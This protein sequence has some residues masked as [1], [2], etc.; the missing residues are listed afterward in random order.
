MEDSIGLSL[1][2]PNG[3]LFRWI[4]LDIEKKLQDGLVGN[5][6]IQPQ[7]WFVL[8]ALGSAFPLLIGPHLEAVRKQNEGCKERDLAMAYILKVE[9]QNHLW[10]LRNI[11]ENMLSRLRAH[12]STCI[13]AEIVLWKIVSFCEMSITKSLTSSFLYAVPY[14]CIMCASRPSSSFSFEPLVSLTWIA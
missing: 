4:F 7:F 5:R 13:N 11:S 14:S 8:C 10:L 3:L 12:D 2:L 6:A 1:Q 9:G